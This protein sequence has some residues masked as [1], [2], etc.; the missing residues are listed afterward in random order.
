MKRSGSLGTASLRLF[1]LVTL[2][3]QNAGYTLARK[4]STKTENVSPSEVLLVAEIFK[5]VIAI[6]FTLTDKEKT[7]APGRGF[8]KLKWL[9]VNSVKMLMLAGIY[10]AM[11]LLSFVSLLYIG[12]GEFTI[13]AQLKILTTAGCSVIFLRT[14]LSGAKWRALV[15]LVLSCVLVASPSFSRTNF[16]SMGSTAPPLDP[17]ADS[18]ADAA[19][20][21]AQTALTV[22]G[23]A[24]VTLEVLLSGFASIYFEKVVKSTSEVISIWERN[25]Q[26]GIYSI[27]MYGTIILTDGSGKGNL[28]QPRAPW[29]NWSSL[30]VF[31]SVM[32]AAGGLLVAATLKYADSILKALSTAGAI[33]LSTVLGHFLLDGPMDITMVIGGF[34]AIMSIANYTLDVAAPTSLAPVTTMPPSDGGGK[35]DGALTGTESPSVVFHKA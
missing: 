15:Q 24:A 7:D 19:S 26:L 3:L 21:V 31:I 17:D 35:Q 4:Y 1:I 13:C 20:V 23:F 18:S 25:F 12:A 8:S 22:L 28:G 5:M 29:T 2:C 16:R 14:S 11:N 9:A 27:L 32:S 34:T 10:A 33:V 6:W 30:T